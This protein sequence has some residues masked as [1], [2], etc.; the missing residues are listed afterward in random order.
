MQKKKGRMEKKKKKKFE[1]LP[2]KTKTAGSSRV[3]S[4]KMPLLTNQ[5]VT[6]GH[7]TNS[8]IMSQ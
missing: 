6:R 5:N 2:W 7:D 1:K 8:Y 4:E 3:F